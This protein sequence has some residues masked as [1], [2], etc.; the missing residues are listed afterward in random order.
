MESIGDL[1]DDMVNGPCEV[2]TRRGVYL[3]VKICDAH[4]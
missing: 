2:G 4:A 1:D 3:F